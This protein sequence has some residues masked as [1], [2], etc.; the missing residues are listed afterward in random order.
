MR[1]SV[2]E[3]IRALVL[4]GSYLLTDHAAEEM[5]E[6]GLTVY[7]VEAVLLSGDIV[8][9]QRDRDSV[10][11]VVVGAT[12]ASETATAVVRIEGPVIVITVFTGTP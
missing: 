1:P 3:R 12:T 9:R 10:K 7:D 11:Y 4:A 5:E 6:D 8:A 2:A